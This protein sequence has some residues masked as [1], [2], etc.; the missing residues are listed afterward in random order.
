[1]TGRLMLA[2]VLAVSA[3]GMAQ[4]GPGVL[5][6]P[7]LVPV[8]SQAGMPGGPVKQE[9]IASLS[10]NFRLTLSGKAG[11]KSLG[12][13]SALTSSP[14]IQISGPM[15]G[16]ELSA[17]YSISG[18]LEEKEGKILFAYTISF[19]VPVVTESQSLRP[20]AKGEAAAVATTRNIQY[21]QHS[22]NGT[23]RM[24][25]GKTYEVLKA[26]GATYTIVVAPEDEK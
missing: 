12:E 8:G 10:S 23:L 9:G 19:S 7:R 3:V 20:S 16:S 17:T 21:Q 15:D 13:L 2:M 4:N 14:T 6:K 18:L 1:M 26:G 5:P 24:V 22:A 11:D 25:P